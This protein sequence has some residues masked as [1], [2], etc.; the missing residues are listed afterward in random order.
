MPG[1]QAQPLPRPDE[2]ITQ[3]AVAAEPRAEAVAVDFAGVGLP[4]V[5]ELAERRVAAVPQAAQRQYDSHQRG[6]KRGRG[7][8]KQEEW[9]NTAVS[10][11]HPIGNEGTDEIKEICWKRLARRVGPTSGACG[12]D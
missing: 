5:V 6:D 7:D 9:E 4:V 2:E 3:E 1:V 12:F 8:H 11:W 10:D